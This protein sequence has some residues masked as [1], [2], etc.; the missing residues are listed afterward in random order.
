VADQFENIAIHVLEKRFE[1]W[2]HFMR[3]APEYSI[4][5]EVMD[6]VPA[7]ADTTSTSTTTQG[8]CGR[9]R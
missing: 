2:A 3:E 8:W 9:P 5:L 4:G 6:D 7:I 1:N